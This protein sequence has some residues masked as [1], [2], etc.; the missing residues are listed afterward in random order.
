MGVFVVR[1]F[2]YGAE[3]YP[4]STLVAMATKMGKF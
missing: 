1:Q 3:I 2:N 4:K